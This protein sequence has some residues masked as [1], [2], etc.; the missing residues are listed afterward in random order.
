V[1]SV[2]FISYSVI[3]HIFVLIVKVLIM[4]W[5]VLVLVLLFETLVI[6]FHAIASI[7]IESLLE[8]VPVVIHLGLHLCFDS[9]WVLWLIMLPISSYL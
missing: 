6:S 5:S 1:A 2:L 4:L 7:S 8:I 3:L 9:G